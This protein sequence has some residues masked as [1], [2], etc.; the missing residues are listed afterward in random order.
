MVVK[1]RTRSPLDPLKQKGQSVL[2]ENLKSLWKVLFSTT[3][4]FHKQHYSKEIFTWC[5]HKP[6]LISFLHNGW[7]KQ[8]YSTDV[9]SLSSVCS[10]AIFLHTNAAAILTDFTT[11]N[12]I[13]SLWEG[14]LYVTIQAHHW[15]MNCQLYK[16]IRKMVDSLFIY[17]VRSIIK[18]IIQFILSIKWSPKQICI[19]YG[20]TIYVDL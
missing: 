15:P 5:N 1:L 10:S 6:N 2:I 14:S 4:S 7:L 18:S 16:G 17:Q 8:T 3:G 9:S 11:A 13:V 19:F 12:R 20:V